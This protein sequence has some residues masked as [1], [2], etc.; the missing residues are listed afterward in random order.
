MAN[1]SLLWIPQDWSRVTFQAGHATWGATWDGQL[2]KLQS[3]R[4]FPSII[5]TAAPAVH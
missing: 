1:A 5:D 3:A 2:A 4:L